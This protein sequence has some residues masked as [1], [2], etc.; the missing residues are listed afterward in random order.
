MSSP[1]SVLMVLLPGRDALCVELSPVAFL[2]AVGA[3]MLPLLTGATLQQLVASPAV[4]SR[5]ATASLSHATE[6]SQIALLDTLEESERPVF[7]AAVVQSRPTRHALGVQLAPRLRERAQEAQ[8]APAIESGEGAESHEPAEST[9]DQ[10]VK[11]RDVRRAFALRREVLGM[12]AERADALAT[13]HLHMQAVHLSESLDVRPFDDMGRALAQPFA[14]LRKLMRCR[15]T[16]HEVAIDPN[17][18]RILTQIS[19][20]YDRPIQLISGHRTPNTIGTR[21][22]SQHVLGR[23]ADIRLRGVSLNALRALAV[24]LGARGVGMYPEKGF[25][26]VDVRKKHRYFWLYTEA[27]GEQRYPDWRP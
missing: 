15:I 26:H 19:S 27:E 13:G 12:E 7:A 1:R 16:G 18:I 2:G 21:P 9:T 10:V 22:T 4:T 24:K 14:A 3:L 25:L 8:E 23:A 6:P 11:A 17:L 5:A 20:A